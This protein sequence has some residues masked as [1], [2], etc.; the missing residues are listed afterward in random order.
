MNT[1]FKKNK[2]NKVVQLEIINNIIN[3]VIFR[4]RIIN[5]AFLNTIFSFL[6]ICE[7]VENLQN[8]DF[9]IAVF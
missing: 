7:S 4:E 2:E 1:K 6:D 9:K 8:D 5:K 3:S